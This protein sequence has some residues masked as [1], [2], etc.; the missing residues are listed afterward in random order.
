MPMI[1]SVTGLT[2][3]ADKRAFSVRMSA[4]YAA[5]FVVIGA[6]MAYW[7][8]WL[9]SKSFGPAEIGWIAAAPTLLRLFLTP[10]IAF[11]ADRTGGH[12]RFILALAVLAAVALCLVAGRS[13]FW[14]ILILNSVVQLSL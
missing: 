13:A 10:A 5:L 2:S 7:P 8:S 4:F 1:W 12:A 11:F 6:S 9:V 14:A 3:D